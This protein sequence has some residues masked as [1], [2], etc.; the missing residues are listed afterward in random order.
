MRSLNSF[1]W[2]VHKLD[3]GIIIVCIL[4]LGCQ[5]L[6]VEERLKILVVFDLLSF[7]FQYNFEFFVVTF[8][9]VN[10]GVDPQLLINDRW[11]YTQKYFPTKTPTA[12]P[13][14]ATNESQCSAWNLYWFFSIYAFMIWPSLEFRI[15]DLNRSKFRRDDFFGSK[16][17]YSLSTFYLFA[18]MTKKSLQYL[19][20]N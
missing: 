1:S 15:F 20:L 5:H 18:S 6:N 11:Q 8:A 13:V 2:L 14:R 7:E 17:S 3:V 19:F 16:L 12:L 4:T 9:L 10:Q